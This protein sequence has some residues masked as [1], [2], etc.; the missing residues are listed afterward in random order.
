MPLCVVCGA[1]YYS[2]TLAEV[3]ETCDCGNEISERIAEVMCESVHGQQEFDE[4]CDAWDEELDTLQN[5]PAIKSAA[6]KEP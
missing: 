3:E 4:I 2:E 1:D 5:Y 6:K